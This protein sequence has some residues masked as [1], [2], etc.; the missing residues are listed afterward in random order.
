[1][2]HATF[3]CLVVLCCSLLEPIA[4]FSLPDLLSNMFAAP[5]TTDD[6]D[7]HQMLLSRRTIHA[8]EATLPDHWE[9]SLDR[10]I[11]A[12]TFAPNHKRT[13]PWRFHLLGKEAI[14][15]VCELNAELVTANKGPTA[16][17]NKLKRW[18]L[19]PG[20]LVVTQVVTIE[21][22]KKNKN[23]QEENESM[24]S[25][26]GLVREDYAAV[27]CA[28]HSI[29]LSLHADGIGTKWTSGPVNFDPKF[30]DAVGGVP[31]NERVVGTLWFGTASVTP[32]PPRKRLAVQDV[33][34]RHD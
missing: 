29:C 10:A 2:K 31:K 17:D 33:L 4:A 34:S 27:C 6:D 13:E 26:N 30:G 9:T 12:A 25:P 22:D 19:L 7:L 11:L 24:L 28:I 20:W 1:M 23:H 8:F 32:R 18:L 15:R 14:Q 16:G 3:Y 5:T 21:D